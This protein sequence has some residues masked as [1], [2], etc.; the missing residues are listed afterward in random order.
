MW[1]HACVD[2]ANMCNHAWKEIYKVHKISQVYLQPKWKQIP[3][4][5]GTQS[6]KEED[7]ATLGSSGRERTLR[8]VG[9]LWGNQRPIAARTYL[10]SPR[11]KRYSRRMLQE[12]RHTSSNSY[13]D[14][15]FGVQ[16]F[17]TGGPA[18]SWN[19]WFV[20]EKQEGECPEQEHDVVKASW[21]VKKLC[22][23]VK[24]KTR[25]E[26]V[27]TVT[28]PSIFNY[29]ACLSHLWVGRFPLTI[30]FLFT[31]KCKTLP[32]PVWIPGWNFPGY[33]LDP[34]SYFAGGMF[35]SKS[36]LV[37]GGIVRIQH[38]CISLLLHHTICSV[39]TEV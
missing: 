2:M 16:V 17:A 37:S 27:S 20:G 19:W 13:Q 14:G 3:L 7:P 32:S 31:P 30:I 25:R 23:F 6:E 38:L 9:C 39:W 24:M 36:F 18:S 35:Y 4:A 15:C 26:E 28:W 1:M 33:V 5:H 10:S 12:F 34:W 11:Y 22:S 29:H 21:R 8:G